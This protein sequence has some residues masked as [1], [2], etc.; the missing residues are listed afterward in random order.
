MANQMFKS[1]LFLRSPKDEKS[2]VYV[3]IRKDNEKLRLSSEVIVP[4]KYWDSNSRTILKG[5]PDYLFLNQKLLSFSAMVAKEVAL[6]ELNNSPMD[7]L[8]NIILSNMGKSSVST[9]SIKD[10]V[11]KFYRWWAMTEFGEH[12]PTRQNWNHFVVFEEFIKMTT[13]EGEIPFESIDYE[14][15]LKFKAFLDNNKR[16]KPNTTATHLRDLKAIMTEAR[17]RGKHNSSAYLV[18][19]KK[20]EDVD[21]TYMTI[22]EINRLYN[23]RLLGVRAMARDLFVLGCHTAM[24]YSDYSKLSMAHISKGNIVYKTQKTDTTVIIPAH[25]RVIEIL[26][27]WQGSAPPVSLTSLNKIIKQ[28]CQ[29]L[30][31]FDDLIPIKEGRTVRYMERYNFISTHTARR[32]GATNMYL[33]GIPAQSIMKITGHTTEASF[34][35]YLRITKEQNAKLLAEND[36]F[37]R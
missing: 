8:K 9:G 14:F 36:F 29:E 19:K 6:A 26:E 32:S 20:F 23:M 1:R 22:E 31:I 24:R 2:A 34:M 35:K 28:V 33:A 5:C 17:N 7:D 4:T 10:G 12:H 15:Y 25:P 30:G 11:V 21:T 27:R 18:I 16:Y 3:E 13:P 37:K